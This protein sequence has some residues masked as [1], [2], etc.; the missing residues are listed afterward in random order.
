MRKIFANLDEKVSAAV[1]LFMLALAFV[2]VVARYVFKASLS[3][4]EEI[5]TMLLVFI[6]TVGAGIAAKRRSHLG[7]SALTDLLPGKYQK[8]VG[9]YANFLGVVVSFILFYTGITMTVNEYKLGQISIGLQVP[10][11]IYSMFVPLGA[12]AMTYH[13]ARTAFSSL[14][15][16]NESA[17]NAPPVS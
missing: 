10:T 3:Y 4:T 1:L 11:W 17:E 15:G 7:L 8:F 9:F 2:N 14:R 16:G 5:T 6:S 12:A 13:F